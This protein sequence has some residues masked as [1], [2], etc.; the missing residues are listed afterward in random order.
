[1]PSVHL[2]YYYNEKILP[3]TRP[4]KRRWIIAEYEFWHK[5]ENLWP[6]VTHSLINAFIIEMEIY[7]I[8][9]RLFMIMHTKDEFDFDRKTLADCTDAKI[10][11]W[12]TLMS[13]FQQ[14]LPSANRTEKWVLM[15]RIFQL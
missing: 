5:K 11:E 9:N 12:E 2:I 4:E 6:E 13:N 8:G 10:M 1:M 14:P 7:R 15:D 3:G